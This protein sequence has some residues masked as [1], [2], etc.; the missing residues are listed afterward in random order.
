LLIKSTDVFGDKIVNLPFIYHT[1]E[2]IIDGEFVA[3]F[4]NDGGV[5]FGGV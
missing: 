1:I 5:D 3:T 4:C 2:P